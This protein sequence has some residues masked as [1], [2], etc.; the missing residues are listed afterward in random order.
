MTLLSPSV[1][2]TVAPV[3]N[4]AAVLKDCPICASEKVESLFV[5]RD[6]FYRLEGRFEV[7]RC[8]SCGVLFT[9]P[10]PEDMAIYYP[11]QYHSHV[12]FSLTEPPTGGLGGLK[13][14][15]RSLARTHHFNYGISSH[16]IRGAIEWVVT[17]PLRGRTEGWFGS[18]PRHV[19]DGRVLDV[20]C[21]S[22]YWLA[23][24]QQLWAWELWGV[25]PSPLA[26]QIARK[27]GI[28]H[29]IESD[30]PQ[31]NLPENFFDV[32]RI[33][34]VL[35]HASSPC[36]VLDEAYRV[37]KPGGLLIV[38]VPNAGS[39]MFKLFRAYWFH[40]DLPRHLFHFSKSVLVKVVREA[41]FYIT[42]CVSR[43]RGRS[44]LFSS[45]QLI[46]HERMGKGIFQ[47]YALLPGE[48][49]L[50][51]TLSIAFWLLDHIGLGDTLEL[52]ARKLGVD[53]SA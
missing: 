42:S 30:L 24:L 1:L 18:L 3:T 45:L 38:G 28:A 9:S 22:G 6:R 16:G 13:S 44:S 15:L 52:H 40:L 8:R 48:H 53:G 26:C 37:L 23:T 7:E 20:G 19:K 35:E 5:G 46:I 49:A 31:A 29:V 51:G 43:T 4:A 10:Q 25:E 2:D 33:W 17:W 41:K 36:Q 21:G 39:L 50:Q 34:H 27:H 14:K 32:V 47:P 11:A 12:D